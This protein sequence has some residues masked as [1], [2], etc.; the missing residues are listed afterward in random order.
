MKGKGIKNIVLILLIVIMA[1]TA[2]L[3]IR[4]KT[5]GSQ[6]S[7]V[8]SYLNANLESKTIFILIPEHIGS[9]DVRKVEAIRVTGFGWVA[10]AMRLFVLILVMA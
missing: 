2:L 10:K 4:A 9:R 1:V 6:E 3:D 5:R 7:D 8:W